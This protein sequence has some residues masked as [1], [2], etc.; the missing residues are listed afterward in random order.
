MNYYQAIL[1]IIYNIQI[2]SEKKQVFWYLE[3]S[4]QL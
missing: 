2:I 3:E 1:Q 4:L